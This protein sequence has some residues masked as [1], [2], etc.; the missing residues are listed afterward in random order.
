MI[1]VAEPILL[2]VGLVVA[3]VGAGLARG[4]AARAT[5]GTLLA[6]LAVALSGPRLDAEGSGSA[7]LH[8]FAVDPRRSPEDRAALAAALE[9]A[10]VQKPDEQ[11][12]L[13]AVDEAPR[14]L[15][16][17]AA[18]G[19]L[20]TIDGPGGAARW[21]EALDIAAQ[22]VP[23]D[24]ELTVTVWGD[25]AGLRSED[26]QRFT[27]TGAKLTARPSPALEAPRLQGLRLPDGPEAVAGGALRLA[28]TAGGSVKLSASLRDSAGRVHALGAVPDGEAPE[29]ALPASAEAGP[30]TLIIEEVDRTAAV[31][32]ERAL[33]LTR[34]P[35]AWVATADRG[36]AASLRGLLE[37]EGA[38]VRG[39]SL[40]EL[41]DLPGLAAADRPDLLVLAGV[42]A[43]RLSAGSQA[44][45][46]AWVREGGH[47]VV[48]GGAEG[49]EL[50]GW[51]DAPLRA[52][53]PLEADPSGAT[54]DP[55]VTLLVVLDKSG[56]MARPAV[57]GAGSV[58]EGLTA[59]MRGGR[60]EGSRIRLAAEG[61]VES[62]KRLRDNTDY[63]AVLGVDTQPMWLLRPT[64]VTD[65][66]AISQAARNLT[67]GGGGIYITTAMEAAAP[68]ILAATT[69]LKH[70]V[71][72]ADASDVGEQRRAK[73]GE[74]AVSFVSSLRRA[75]VT[76]SVVGIGGVGDRDLLYLQNLARVGGGQAWLAED[77]RRL[78]ALFA[79]ETER[80]LGAP[81]PA[82]LRLR[83]EADRWSPAL[84]RV[85]LPSAPMLTGHHRL[86]ARPGAVVSVRTTQGPLLAGATV[87]LGQTWAL[88]TDVGARSAQPWLGWSGWGTLWANL[89]R[90]STHEQDQTDDVEAILTIRPDPDHPG[91]SR[92]HLSERDRLGR[93]RAPFNRTISVRRAA[94]GGTDEAPVEVHPLSVVGPGAWEASVL[95]PAN[96]ALELRP[97]EPEGAA[98]PTF[99]RVT[100]AEDPGAEPDPAVISA[101]TA[102]A[103]ARPAP[104]RRSP[105]WWAFAAAAALLLPVDAWA[106]RIGLRTAGRR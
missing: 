93:S 94:K 84:D 27:Q 37:A 7:A 22:A 14:R 12:I 10:R 35:R 2:V 41:R 20:P 25:L 48:T 99:L 26:A 46:D 29:L 80:L 6:C 103:G 60:P 73:G 62:V 11:V 77:P 49:W 72:F 74:E 101:W 44:Q 76:F 58:N 32:H 56:S 78:P 105:L 102:E 106:R 34:P 91:R 71:L 43:H 28:W 33:I 42:G 18:L 15:P 61:V 57:L 63:I 70:V 81:P 67:S 64:L 9:A 30:A 23:P 45:I 39:L 88:A 5:R 59:R 21:Q 36:E 66:A 47:L 51:E 55:A 87:G 31:R 40:A 82:S 24:G 19:A 52:I 79:R 86:R 16:A 38:E 8:L 13:I 1:S 68:V 96:A 100:E 89:L 104:V 92:V 53:L 17:D 75:G 69:P 98:G 90:A 95:L 97:S 83:A 54:L 65:R 50:G 4:A 85:S 3:A